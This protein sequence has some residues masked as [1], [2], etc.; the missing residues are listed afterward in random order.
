MGN[1]LT[2]SHYSIFQERGL[3]HSGEFGLIR[4]LTSEIPQK[5][6]IGQRH[7]K[8]SHLFTINSR[9]KEK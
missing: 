9:F 3:K 7:M 5:Y 6:N 4:S 8:K 2:L 1:T